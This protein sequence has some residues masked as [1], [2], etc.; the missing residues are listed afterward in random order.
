M[1]T[2][3]QYID[4]IAGVWAR[5]GATQH[6]H[7][8]GWQNCPVCGKHANTTH[9]HD[10]GI[11]NCRACMARATPTCGADRCPICAA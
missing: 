7:H 10:H 9:N 4:H 3:K 8:N 2:P 11:N 1:P 6:N 5:A